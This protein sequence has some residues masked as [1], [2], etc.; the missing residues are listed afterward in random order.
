M[1]R[2]W[3]PPSVSRE[4]REVTAQHNVRVALAVDTDGPVQRF[5]NPRLRAIDPRLSLV[6]AKD[7]ALAPGV[8]PGFWHVRRDNSPSPVT[9]WPW[10]APDGSFLEPDS[11]L[12]E[13]LRTM[14]MQSTRT[15]R[16]LHDAAVED[17][18]R[19][20]RE[21]ELGHEQRVDHM[22]NRLRSLNRTSVLINRDA[23]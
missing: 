22:M 10:Q 23:A 20:A 14:D 6:K 12:E 3:V 11:R 16:A 19:R 4:Q 1:S 9:V 17:D 5:W 15:D 13:W 21:D 8:R 18:R 2:L 7:D